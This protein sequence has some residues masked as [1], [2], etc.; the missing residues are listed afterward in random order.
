M[1]NI[2]LKNI[3]K[4]INIDTLLFDILL[5]IIVNTITSFIVNNNYL[6]FTEE[7]DMYP[8]SIVMG[9]LLLVLF[10]SIGEIIGRYKKHDKKLSWWLILVIL[11]FTGFSILLISED[12]F[13]ERFLFRI[14][15]V[16][17]SIV[18]I[19][20]FLLG[21]FSRVKN[22]AK[23]IKKTGIITFVIS[24]MA[25]IF[26]VILLFF[27]GENIFDPAYLTFIVSL[28]VGIIV[29]F[30][31]LPP[32]IANFI[33]KNVN[34]QKS[35][36]YTFIILSAVTFSL[37]DIITENNLTI[38]DAL[39]FTRKSGMYP[40]AYLPLLAYR[41]LFAMAPPKNKINMIIGVIVLVIVILF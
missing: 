39:G 12:M 5:L 34:F 3:F 23:S 16:S 11:F 4:N 7:T 38:T 40:V 27:N 41:F 36:I 2:S 30:L 22:F 25:L 14:F 33:Q 29:F 9:F 17:S 21:Y 1:R 24:L 35:L 18:M 15:I 19:A 32:R 10:I 26:L 13:K 20:G 6:I 8:I 28:F 31:I 37:W